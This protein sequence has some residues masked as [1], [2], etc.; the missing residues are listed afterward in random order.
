MY[1]LRLFFFSILALIYKRQHVP[2]QFHSKLCPLVSFILLQMIEF[3]P[4]YSCILFHYV[5]GHHIFFVQQCCYKTQWGRYLFNTMSS[6]LLANTPIVGLQGNMAFHFQFPK[7]SPYSMV[8]ALIY[9]FTNFF[10]NFHLFQKSFL[11]PFKISS[12]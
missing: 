8:V 6:C 1:I 11:L 10:F 5:Y 4:F 9:M 3:H 12:I 2:G 7:K